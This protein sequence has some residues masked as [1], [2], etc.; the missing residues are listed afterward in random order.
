MFV[1]FTVVAVWLGWNA[2]L[3]RQRK[4]FIQSMNLM[5]GNNYVRTKIDWTNLPPILTEDGLHSFGVG[6][7]HKH[8]IYAATAPCTVSMLRQWLG[9]E[10]ISLLTYRPGPEPERIARLFP[11]AT[12]AVPATRH[13]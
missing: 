1:A 3:I 8:R 4:E 11:E 7:A 2:N 9:D 6:V 5:P 13:K 12:I 10:P